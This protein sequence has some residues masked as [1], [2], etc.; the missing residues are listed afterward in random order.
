MNEKTLKETLTQIKEDEGY[1]SV[2]YLCIAGKWTIGYGRNFQ[3]VPFTYQELS[4][5]LGL[6]KPEDLESFYF[7]DLEKRVKFLDEVELKK[8][9]LNYDLLNETVKSVLVQMAYQMGSAGLYKFRKTLQFAR[10]NK[11]EEMASEMMNSSWAKQTPKRAKRLSD[12]IK[13]LAK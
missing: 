3:D 13:A 1:K 2:P 9:I 12:K 11:F 8:N 5:L 4:V 7:K 6:R 10:E